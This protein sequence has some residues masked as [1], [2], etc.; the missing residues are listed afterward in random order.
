MEGGD[1]FPSKS[2][3]SVNSAPFG[4]HLLDIHT[5][6]LHAVPIL[7]LPSVSEIQFAD[8]SLFLQL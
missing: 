2:V 7:L 8:A 4:A 6:Q 1:L 3:F 5:Y